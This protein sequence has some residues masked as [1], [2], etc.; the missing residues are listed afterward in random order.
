MGSL[1]LP[2]AAER[3]IFLQYHSFSLMLNIQILLA[4]LCS[5]ARFLALVVCFTLSLYNLQLEFKA[6][7]VDW[8]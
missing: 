8:L 1:M 2:R 6:P 7:S 5:I 4:M 3:R